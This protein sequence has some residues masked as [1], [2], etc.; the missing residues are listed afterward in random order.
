MINQ[1]VQTEK[2]LTKCG[3]YE[4]LFGAKCLPWLTIFVLSQKHHSAWKTWK[5]YQPNI[6]T[7]FYCLPCW[8]TVLTETKFEAWEMECR[9]TCQTTFGQLK[10]CAV[11]YLEELLICFQVVYTRSVISPGN[12]QAKRSWYQHNSVLTA[13][14][15]G[16]GKAVKGDKRSLGAVGGLIADS[17]SDVRP[18]IKFMNLHSATLFLFLSYMTFGGPLSYTPVTCCICQFLNGHTDSPKRKLL[19]TDAT[20]GPS[21]SITLGLFS[22]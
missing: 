5:V 1:S 8:Q 15:R 11:I 13:K 20:E 14:Q 7:F 16:R 9:W 17:P 2:Y 22:G 6:L 19:T 21:E 12:T 10:L 4:N 18:S 3:K